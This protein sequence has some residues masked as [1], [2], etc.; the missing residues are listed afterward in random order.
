MPGDGPGN[1][2]QSSY[3]FVPGEN[4]AEILYDVFG[5]Q[6]Y[7]VSAHHQVHYQTKIF[8]PKRELCSQIPVDNPVL[9]KT[10]FLSGLLIPVFQ[11]GDCI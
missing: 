9:D 3:Y 5:L 10:A 7:P 8:H 6:D 1:R 2:H 4:R 11:Y